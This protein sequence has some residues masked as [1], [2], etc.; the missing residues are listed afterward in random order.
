MIQECPIDSRRGLYKNIVLSG[1][2]TMFKDFGRRLQ[3]DVKKFADARLKASEKLSGG[4]IKV[5]G[6]LC[7]PHSFIRTIT[8]IVN[9]ALTHHR[10]HDSVRS[11]HQ[12]TSRSSLTTCNGT[13]CGSAGACWRPPPSFTR[14]ATQRRT[15]TNTELQS[16]GTTLSSAPCKQLGPKSSGDV[17]LQSVKCLRASIANTF[18]QSLRGTTR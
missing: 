8:S 5:R 4:T 18:V 14:S 1:G 7:L 3:R 11:Q 6:Q 16:V 2:S 17:L 10:H 9:V 15:T 13:P 12:W